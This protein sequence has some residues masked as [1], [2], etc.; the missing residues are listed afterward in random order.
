[1]RTVIRDR[2]GR[3]D[4]ASQ[5]D[6]SVASVVGTRFTLALV[7]LLSGATPE[8]VHEVIE[9]AAAADVVERLA[10]GRYAFSH[11]MIREALYREIPGGERAKLHAAIVDAM[12]GGRAEGTIADRAYHALRAAPIIG[13][14]RAVTTAREGA[15][16]AMQVHA[17]EDAAELLRRALAVLDLAAGDAA[18]QKLRTEVTAAL[19]AVKSRERPQDVLAAPAPARTQDVPGAP[20]PAPTSIGLVRDGELWTV[21]FGDILVRLKDSRGV[22]MLARLV[23][24]PGQEIHALV[25]CTSGG[26][27]TAAGDSGEVLD[28]EAIDA[29]RERL[30]EV[31]EELREAEAWN[32]PA[33]AERARTEMDLLRSELSRAVGLGGRS[34]RAGSDAERARVNAQRRL[35]DAVRRITEHSAE[36]GR[37]LERAVRTGTFCAYVPDERAARSEG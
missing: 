5:K 21:T 23:E 15:T 20:A 31:E 16:A 35:R 30:V 14:T 17:F 28:R 1:V 29:Y 25:L 4:D 19:A 33:R 12:E 34:R 10:P 22:Q 37:H 27:T 36:I 6:L 18:V 9:R 24:Q 2:L 32:D 8:A 13:V 7:G 3:L 26:E 11:T